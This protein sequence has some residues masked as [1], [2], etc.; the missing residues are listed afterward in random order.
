MSYPAIMNDRLNK[1]VSEAHKSNARRMT[2][3]TLI[4][5]AAIIVYV[6]FSL[7]GMTGPD[8]GFYYEAIL[9]MFVLTLFIGGI[10]ETI[11]ELWT[12]GNLKVAMRI[13]ADDSGAL[14]EKEAIES[15]L[16]LIKFPWRFSIRL[17]EQWMVTIPLI[18]FSIRL[19]YGITWLKLFN[20]SIGI[21]VIFCLTSVFNYFIVKRVYNPY[22]AKALDNFPG[23]FNREEM[24]THQVSYRQKVFM[25]LII[26]V[27]CIVWVST[28]FNALYQVR[29]AEHMRGQ[30]ISDMLKEMSL[31]LEQ[32]V[33]MGEIDVRLAELLSHFRFCKSEKILL[34]DSSGNTIIGPTVTGNERQ[35]IGMLPQISPEAERNLPR[36]GRHLLL[37]LDENTLEVMVEGEHY[38]MTV[39][40]LMEGEV[41]LITLSPVEESISLGF[42]ENLIPFSMF[43]AAIILALLFALFMSRD[44]LAP[45]GRMLSSTG[46]VADGDLSGFEPIAADDELGVAATYH[47]RMVESL[48]SA[49]QSINEASRSI[50]GAAG[51]IVKRTDVV[52]QGTE[53]QSASVE[54]VTAS[55]TEMSQT[56]KSIADNVE[57][58]AQSTEASSASVLELSATIEQ[59]AQNAE[60]FAKAVSETTS[61]IH[62]M[63]ISIREVA[64]NVQSVASRAEQ[65]AHAASRMQEDMR[66]VESLAVDSA[67]LSEH[68]TGDAEEGVQAVTSTIRGIEKIQESSDEA[69]RVI[70]GLSKRAR[71]IGNIV[72]VI[73]DITEETNLLALNAAIIAAQAGEHGRAFSVVADEIRDLA[74]RTQTS[75][76]VIADQIQA[77]QDEARNAVQAVE[78]GSVRIQEGVKLSERAGD[79]LRE[80]LDSSQQTL[81][82]ARKISGFMA[83]QTRRSEELLKFIE[84][85]STMISQVVT[86]T[87]EQAKG[88]E[89]IIKAADQMRQISSH[90][91]KATRE[92]AAGSRQINQAIENINQI[93]NFIN[94]SQAE[95]TRA[96]D[97]VLAAMRKISETAQDNAVSVEKFSMAVNNLT[98]LASELREMV[99]KF[100]VAEKPSQPGQTL[101]EAILSSGPLS[102]DD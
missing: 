64:D 99:K 70:Q 28:R 95:Q 92:Q 27:A 14:S 16:A 96:A 19:F 86:A 54:E 80:I 78:R 22:L 63:S 57:T 82:M 76:A 35:V 31:E 37:R 87:G 43:T 91:H 48:R 102:L 1:L 83:E 81:E 10:N 73:D 36:L 13:V 47:H 89:M 21:M 90:V 60:D 97:Q 11:F 51:E 42:V 98:F 58:V 88:T 56:I 94:K 40:A 74:E 20:M 3:F 71:E 77:V 100:T 75:T 85:V 29:Q 44:L 49:I 72:N 7:Q 23:F 41:F 6:V 30:F 25:F 2:P 93:V 5:V 59:V 8:G 67:R 65:A 62:E 69:T 15:L 4:G 66:N 24:E 55:M 33:A 17:I 32:K 34:V 38:L 61:S 39:H 45:L 46:R 18:I 9:Y 53:A 52:A 68:V 26:L 79:A 101:D 50:D 84:N 12:R